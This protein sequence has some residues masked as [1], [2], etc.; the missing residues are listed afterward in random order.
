MEPMKPMTP[1]KAMEPMAPMAPMSPPASDWWPE[2]LSAPSST[3]AQGSLRY[4][5]F[6]QQRRLVV[7]RDG[8]VQQYDT[9]DHAIHGV[10]QSGHGSHRGALSFT[11]QHGDVDLDT[12]RRVD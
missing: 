5:F 11:S 8:D 2:G 9:G 7:D 6:P 12:L 4:A 1:M 3:G 10:S